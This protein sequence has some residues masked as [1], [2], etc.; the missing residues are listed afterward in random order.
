V[1]LLLTAVL[2]A[3]PLAG[4]D[5]STPAT[6]PSPTPA[7]GSLPEV[8]LQWTARSEEGV[9]GYLV[10]RSHRREGPYRRINPE[11]IHARHAPPPA[12]SSYRFVDAE[13]ESGRTYYYYLDTVS[14][15]GLKQRLS[16]VITKEVAG[17]TVR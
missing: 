17:E 7:A 2:A 9:Y 6:E 16:G 1:G 4:A 14:N 15:G 13:V 10:Y 5:D 3:P 11:I 8:V 12:T